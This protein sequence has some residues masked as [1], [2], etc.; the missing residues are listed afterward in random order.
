[1]RL[2]PIR[3]R[4]Q[5]GGAVSFDQSFGN[6]L[7]MLPFGLV[8]IEHFSPLLFQDGKVPFVN[9]LRSS[10]WAI[11]DDYAVNAIKLASPFP[12]VPDTISR[13]GIPVLA[14]FNY[15]VDTSLTNFLR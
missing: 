8:R 14:R 9:V 12:P 13:K 7:N 4:L 11:Y 1:M 3:P 6:V 2:V 5:I 10:G 15:M